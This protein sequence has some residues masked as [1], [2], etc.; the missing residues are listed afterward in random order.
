MVS[1]AHSGA[2][3]ILTIAGWLIT[4]VVGPPAAVLL[5]KQNDAGR[6]ASIIVWG[7]ICLYYLLSAALFWNSSMLYGRITVDV[8]FSAALVF[9]CFPLE[10]DR[11][12]KL[13]ISHRYLPIE[14]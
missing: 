13:D 9:F 11:H 1:L 12:A 5:W 6:I 3:G 7:S 8:A 4:L 14:C 2:F 10:R